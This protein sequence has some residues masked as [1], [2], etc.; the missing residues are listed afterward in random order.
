MAAAAISLGAGIAAGQTS[1]ELEAEGLRLVEAHCAECHAIGPDDAS[2]HPEAPAFRTL[3][4][5]Y[6]VEFLAEALVEGIDVGHPDMPL[7]EATQEEMAAI[8]AYLSSI[9]Q[10]P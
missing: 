2:R 1:V 9:Q 7:F 6:P 10:R 4:E 3:S 8:I 5:R